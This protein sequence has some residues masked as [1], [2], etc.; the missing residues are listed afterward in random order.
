MNI[1]N[2]PLPSI[3][4]NGQGVAPFSGPSQKI[5]DLKKQ[6]FTLLPKDASILTQPTKRFDFLA[7]PFEPVAFAQDLIKFMYDNN[8]LGLAANQ[9]GVPYSI[10]AMRGTPENFVCFNPTIVWYSD[11]IVELEEGCL[12]FPGLLIKIKRPQHIRVRFH[13]PNSDI[14]TRKFTGLSARIFQHEYEH[15]QG[16]LYTDNVSKLKLDMAVKKSIKYEKKVN[17]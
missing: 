8:G 13:T 2:K 5:F 17:A 16:K 4:Y 11:A 15:L 12:T 7:P 1:M 14:E 3:I 6:R 10:F 9:I